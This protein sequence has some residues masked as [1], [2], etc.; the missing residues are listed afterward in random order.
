MASNTLQAGSAPPKEIW[1]KAPE[2]SW[3][4]DTRRRAI[5]QE[6]KKSLELTMY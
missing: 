2:Q 3:Q 1:A 5:R 4:E 6:R